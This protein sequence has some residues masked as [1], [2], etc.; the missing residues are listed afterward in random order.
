MLGGGAAPASNPALCWIA[1]HYPSSSLVWS[2]QHKK[3]PAQWD[4]PRRS[5]DS[6]P[7]LVPG[8]KTEQ[9]QNPRP[10]LRM[11]FGMQPPQAEQ[12][13]PSHLQRWEEEPWLQAF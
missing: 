6:Q 7:L 10:C 5:V 9:Q 1:L 2:S 3:A 11:L 13:A 4:F 8:G 12:D